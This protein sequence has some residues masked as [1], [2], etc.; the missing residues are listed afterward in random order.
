[1]TSG[2]KNKDTLAKNHRLTYFKWT[3]LSSFITVSIQMNLTAT[4]NHHCLFFFFNRKGIS[5]RMTVHESPLWET[6]KSHNPS[7]TAASIPS[8]AVHTHQAHT[9]H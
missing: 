8:W 2:K 9:A 4:N 6:F 7:M 1:M 5:A 3:S